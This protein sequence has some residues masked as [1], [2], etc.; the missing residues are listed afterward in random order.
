[1]EDRII[2]AIEDLNVV[3]EYVMR[4]YDRFLYVFNTAAEYIKPH[5]LVYGL[6]YLINKKYITIMIN[7]ARYDIIMKGS[8]N[9]ILKNGIFLGEGRCV[10]LHKSFILG[11]YNDRLADALKKYDPAIKRTQIRLGTN[12]RLIYEKLLAEIVDYVIRPLIP[13]LFYPIR[14]RYEWLY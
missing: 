4:K 1:M 9:K 13:H 7:E 10:G 6:E 3:Q 11:D 5:N 8:D 2:Q 12:I 14:E